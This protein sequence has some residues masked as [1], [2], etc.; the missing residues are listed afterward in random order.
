M[1]RTAIKPVH[2]LLTVALISLLALVLRII[3]LADVPPRW[4][5]GWSIAHASLKLADL[6]TITAA[7][8]HPPLFYILLGAWQS[9]V[10]IN[11]FSDRYLAVLMS[12]PTVPL[13]FATAMAW[14]GGRS[15]SAVRLAVIAAVLMAWLPLAVYYSAVIRMYALA[16]SLVLL[17]TWTALRMARPKAVD[18]TY[19]TRKWGIGV[20]VFA[21]AVGAAGAMLTLYHA[22][23]ALVALAVYVGIDGMSGA[24]RFTTGLRRLLPFGLAILLSLLLYTPWAVY[25]IPQLQQRATADTG[26]VAQQYPISYFAKIGIEGL[27]MSQRIGMAGLGVMGVIVVGALACWGVRS[28]REKMTFAK[29]DHADRAWSSQPL[30]ELSRIAL[31]VLTIVLTVVGVAAAAQR[32]GAGRPGRAATYS[33]GARRRDLRGARARRG[34]GVGGTHRRAG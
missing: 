4:D 33:V 1:L 15:R 30:P 16:P 5:E 28:R 9:V 12:L 23:W 7:D 3:G 17:S 31:P 19:A 18:H 34:E 32:R 29:G 14:G 26:N 8:V 27:T 21:F 22:V 10:G 2:V 11:L 13:A 6:F 24:G 20:Y 25:A